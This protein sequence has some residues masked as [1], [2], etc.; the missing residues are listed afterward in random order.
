MFLRV[1]KW[2]QNF[3]F[4][5]KYPYIWVISCT[6]M[7]THTYIHTC[8]II[9]KLVWIIILFLLNVLDECT[10]SL[11]NLTLVQISANIFF[12]NCVHLIVCQP[13]GSIIVRALIWN[14]LSAAGHNKG[15]CAAEFVQCKRW[16]V[17]Q[18]LGK[19]FEFN[20]VFEMSFLCLPRLPLL[21]QIRKNRNL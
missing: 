5:V 21:D 7:H 1:S 6:C 19:N 13:S 14:V 11:L 2:I 8:I 3:H 4:W 12:L 15:K 17:V 16:K 10:H 20:V 9:S 18:Q